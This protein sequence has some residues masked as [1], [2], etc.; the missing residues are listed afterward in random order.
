MVYLMYLSSLSDRT[1]TSVSQTR[2]GTELSICEVNLALFLKL[3]NAVQIAD[4][5]YVTILCVTLL[6]DDVALANLLE[7]S[8]VEDRWRYARL[9]LA[10]PAR[11]NIRVF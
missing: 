4:D 5:D 1:L 3:V 8:N 2:V 6:T 11:I 10:A 9:T 7:K